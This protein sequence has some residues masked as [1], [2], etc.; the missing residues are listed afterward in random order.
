MERMSPRQLA[1]MNKRMRDKI[2]KLSE[3]PPE[4]PAEPAKPEAPKPNPTDNADF[5]P[6]EYFSRDPFTRKAIA[7]V[8]EETGMNKKAMTSFM[9]VI[10]AMG[11]SISRIRS[12]SEVEPFA[13]KFRNEELKE[14]ITTVSAEDDFKFAMSKAEFKKDVEALIKKDYPSEEWGK[15]ETVKKAFKDVYFNR[16]Q[17][18]AS[19]S[20]REIVEDG[21]I[22]EKGVGSGSA[23]GGVSNSALEAFAKERG[24]GDTKDPVVRKK[25]L[26]AFNAF[27]AYEKS[28][29]N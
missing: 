5:D 11:D 4:K 20:T 12:K 6:I 9:H 26:D 19:Q 13:S 10:G 22:H 21:S 1:A 16:R 2:A 14:A 28:K 25:A 29:K 27:K 7:D 8:M 17:E 24:L 18:F 15:P 23:G 3:K